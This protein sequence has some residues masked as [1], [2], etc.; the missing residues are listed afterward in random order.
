MTD[1][2]YLY[3]KIGARF[4]YTEVRAW[5]VYQ[6]CREG[7]A[8]YRA[9]SE[10]HMTP[11]VPVITRIDTKCCISSTAFLGVGVS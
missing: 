4:W 1:Y 8:M 2:F 9:H 11:S 6:D 3:V 5:Y 7:R 10:M